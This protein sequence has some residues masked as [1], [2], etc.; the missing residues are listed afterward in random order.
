MATINVFRSMT[1]PPRDEEPAY[2][3]LAR[4]IRERIQTGQL[5]PG[6]QLPTKREVADALN[7]S[8]HTVQHA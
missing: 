4:A 8:I 1:L 2:R 6:D 5:R 3:S 7:L